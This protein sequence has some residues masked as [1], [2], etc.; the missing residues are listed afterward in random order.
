MIATIL[1][2]QDDRY[3]IAGDLP[4]RPT[5]DKEL[6]TKLVETHFITQEGGAILPP[7]IKSVARYN[8]A[9]RGMLGIRIPEI[10]DSSVLI[11]NRTKD[12]R[13]SKD[14]KKFRLDNFVRVEG[15]EVWI[16]LK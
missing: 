6:L 5:N 12:K 15:A 16:K 3:L 9:Q 2:D 7:S 11:V 13:T 8:R 14:C 10:A 4:R 1:L